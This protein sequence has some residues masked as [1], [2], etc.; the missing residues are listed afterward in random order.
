MGSEPETSHSLAVLT[1][2]ASQITIRRAS[3]TDV[4]RIV[5][6]LADDQLGAAREVPGAGASDLEPYL[7]AFAMID[8]DP[9]QLLVAA[10]DGEEVV[11]TMQL[12][13]M[14]GLSR[15][16]ALRAQIEG[17][18]VRQDFRDQGLGHAMFEWAIAEA[19]NRGCSLVQLTSDKSRTDAHRFYERLGFVANHEGMKLTL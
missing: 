14:P 18:R 17:V 12:S 6:L 5:E 2:G 10:E 4:S 1:L 9:G 8:A 11:G 19:R 15:R 7:R 13:F 3:G 16:G